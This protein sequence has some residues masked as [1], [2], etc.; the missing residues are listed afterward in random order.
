[1]KRFLEKIVPFTVVVSRNIHAKTP[2]YLQEFLRFKFRG[3]VYVFGKK[4]ENIYNVRIT[5][6]RN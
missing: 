6:N 5:K 2:G 1:M 4:I 3:K